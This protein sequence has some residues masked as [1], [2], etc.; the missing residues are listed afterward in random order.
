MFAP[1]P[2][3]D[4]GWYAIVGILE[5]GTQVDLLRGG[6]SRLDVRRP[7]GQKVTH[8]PELISATFPRERWRKYLI[9]IWPHPKNPGSQT[10]ALRRHYADYLKRHWNETHGGV[11]EMKEVEIYFVWRRVE[12]DFAHLNK[13]RLEDKLWPL[14]GVD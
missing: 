14:P 11:K 1:Y 13:A 6:P 2:L 5:D 8:E 12:P 9:N 7:P 10:G 4:S 3:K